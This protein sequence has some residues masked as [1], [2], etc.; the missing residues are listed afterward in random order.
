MLFALWG[1]DVSLVALSWGVLIAALF[2]IPLLTFG[3]LMLLFAM[4]WVYTLTTRVLR[5]LSG[6]ETAYAEYYRGHAF[7]LLLVSFCA[8]LATMWLLLFCVGKF[9]IAFF[10]IPL[11]FALAAHMPLLKRIPFI[12]ELLVSAAFVFACAVPAYY[13]GFRFS[14]LHML[15]NK[16]LWCLIALFFLFNVIRAE[17]TRYP[18]IPGGALS[19][20]LA[21][22]FVTSLYSI[23][24]H[25]AV[26]YEHEFYCAVCIGCAA[27]HVLSVLRDKYA[28]P[29]SYICSWPLMAAPSLLGVLMFA[30]DMWFN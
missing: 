18:H 4:T 3:P 21:L 25:D 15:F 5:S 24:A 17:K 14:P 12:K 26:D 30:P 2:R 1:V 28:Q 22:V 6:R 19:L 7:L 20:G 8:L 23:L 10:A 11:V 16:H 13:Y 27:V 29:L 9:L